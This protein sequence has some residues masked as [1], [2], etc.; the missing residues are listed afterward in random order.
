MLIYFIML[1]I[2]VYFVFYVGICLG[3]LIIL[4][5]VVVDCFNILIYVENI[6]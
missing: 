1:N 4:F 2:V 6:F 5:K 3:Y